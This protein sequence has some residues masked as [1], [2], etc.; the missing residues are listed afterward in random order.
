MEIL[1]SE[2]GVHVCIHHIK[3]TGYMWILFW[4]NKNYISPE[5]FSW[6]SHHLPSQ[7]H[8]K[9]TR[10]SQ[11]AK[12]NNPHD[13]QCSTLH[14]VTPIN[15]HKKKKQPPT[16]V[17]GVPCSYCRSCTRWWSERFTGQLLYAV[18]VHLKAFGGKKAFWLPM[19]IS[20][21][22]IGSL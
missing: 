20:K 9:K 7:L 15:H 11:V 5:T 22:E 18:G 10:P 19:E 2:V 6:C 4:S 3:C 1:R 8:K 13:I 14:P 17:I 12:T 16:W 21:Q